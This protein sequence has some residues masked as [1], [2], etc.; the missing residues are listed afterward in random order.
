MILALYGK[1]ARFLQ[2]LLRMYRRDWI[3]EYDPHWQAGSL[4]DQAEALKTLGNAM[5]QL[6]YSC[7]DLSKDVY[8][9]N[10]I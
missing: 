10:R 9:K 8:E 7:G 4:Q 3:V 1:F 5:N 6:G 2:K